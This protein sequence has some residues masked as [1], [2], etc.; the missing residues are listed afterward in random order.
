MKR[1]VSRKRP[2]D[3]RESAR[4]ADVVITHPGRIVFPERGLRKLDLAAYYGEVAERLLP[5]VEGRPLT[6]VRCPG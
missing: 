2:G 6:L 5:H 4:V 1:E 3:F